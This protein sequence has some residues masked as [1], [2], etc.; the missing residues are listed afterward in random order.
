MG[1]RESK[2]GWIFRGMQVNGILPM[3]SPRE[4]KEREERAVEMEM[5]MEMV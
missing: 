4:E 1:A 3:S 2:K 5:E